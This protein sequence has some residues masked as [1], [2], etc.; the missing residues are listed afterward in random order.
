MS[1]QLE[2]FEPELAAVESALRD[3]RVAL[4][5]ERQRPLATSAPRR[6]ARLLPALEAI[7]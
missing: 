2:T 3:L 4:E 1:D 7:R 5:S 6:A